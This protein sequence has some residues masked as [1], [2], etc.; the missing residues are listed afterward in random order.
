MFSRLDHRTQS[1]GFRTVDS[2]IRNSKNQEPPGPPI[3]AL[4]H[5]GH[6]I[7]CK[8]RACSSRNAWR[9]VKVAAGVQWVLYKKE[10]GEH[11]AV[12]WRVR[13]KPPCACMAH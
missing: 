4:Q 5:N 1:I 12:R 10:R 2:S 7:G 6:T 3:S 11:A 13:E 9:R 8:T